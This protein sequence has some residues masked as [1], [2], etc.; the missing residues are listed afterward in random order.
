MREHLHWMPAGSQ[1]IAFHHGNG[2]SFPTFPPGDSV[3]PTCESAPSFCSRGRRPLGSVLR[4][5]AG[6]TPILT[7]ASRSFGHRKPERAPQG[8]GSPGHGWRVAH[9][10][11]VPS[12]PKPSQG[13]KRKKVSYLSRVAF[14]WFAEMRRC[15]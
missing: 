10:T 12:T 11:S 6:V 1:Y 4:A 7:P 15:P 13:N 2:K 8:E 5:F 14:V 9:P 3:T